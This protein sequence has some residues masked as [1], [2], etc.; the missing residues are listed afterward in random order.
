MKLALPA[1]LV[2]A[3]LAAQPLRAQADEEAAARAAVTAL[4][5]AMRAGSAEGVRAAFTPDARLQSAGMRP[6]GQAVLRSEQVE[7]F[8]TAV[9]APRDEVWDER[10]DAWD[11]RVDGPLAVVT[12]DYS[13]YAGDRFSHCGINAFQLLRTA[14]GWKI[15]QLVD[16]RRRTGC[17]VDAAAAP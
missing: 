13:F 14:D 11:V 9:G 4:F 6:D 12:T 17:P 3:T 7:N 2:L 10:I 15:F 8:A 1:L 16:T 5:D